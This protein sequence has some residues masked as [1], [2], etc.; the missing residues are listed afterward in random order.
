LSV[1][2]I[3]E[4]EEEEEEYKGEGCNGQKENPKSD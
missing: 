1:E 3:V 2:D 4:F